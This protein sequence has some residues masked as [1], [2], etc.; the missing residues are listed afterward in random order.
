M[1]APKWGTKYPFMGTYSGPSV[2][3]VTVPVTE[4]VSE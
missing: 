3:P 4:G 2:D 1:G